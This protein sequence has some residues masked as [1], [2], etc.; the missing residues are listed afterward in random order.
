MNGDLLKFNDLKKRFDE[1]IKQIETIHETWKQLHEQPDEE[2]HIRKHSVLIDREMAL[3]EEAR[4]VLHSTNRLMA[5]CLTPI[6]RSLL[7]NSN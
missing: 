4:E 3:I 5:R 7:R 2:D 6:S 1:L